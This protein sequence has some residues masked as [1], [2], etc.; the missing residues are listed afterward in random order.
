MDYLHIFDSIEKYNE[1]IG[2]GYGQMPAVGICDKNFDEV[3][4]RPTYVKPPVCELT[5]KG[6]TSNLF[7]NDYNIKSVSIDGEYVYNNTNE[8]TWKEFTVTPDDV[9][10]NNG[11][12]DSSLPNSKMIFIKSVP[13]IEITIE[14]G[15]L[16][17]DE[18]GVIFPYDNQQEI[19]VG[20]FNPDNTVLKDGVLTMD[21]T[22]FTSSFDNVDKVSFIIYRSDSGFLTT[23]IRCFSVDET[24]EEIIIENKNII[25]GDTPL[26]VPD[27]LKLFPTSSLYVD[28]ILIEK[29]DGPLNL[30]EDFIVTYY[31]GS[32]A[33]G[34]SLRIYVD[35]GFFLINDE[36]TLLMPLE[37]NMR[38]TL[39]G[40][41][42]IFGNCETD[43]GGSI[44]SITNFFDTKC[45]VVGKESVKSIEITDDKKTITFESFNR[46]APILL[47]GT[48]ILTY[49]SRAFMHNTSNELLPTQFSSSPYLESITLPK[50]IK[51]FDLTAINGCNNLKTIIC[52]TR[53]APDIPLSYSCNDIPNVI[54]QIPKG[55]DYS[56]WE[57]HPYFIKNNWKIEYV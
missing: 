27:N 1:S 51:N 31:A 55:G 8:R 32:F 6:P 9:S 44:V 14:G 40:T 45:T 25:P 21:F 5:Y 41:A 4:N 23:N 30:D 20:Q 28:Y 10:H 54:V 57:A 29:I 33:G 2:W 46:F 12:L 39:T 36:K 42:M 26:D 13:T 56:E 37:G 35:Y 18:C 19:L 47:Q 38:D 24:T 16:P 50:S 22:S 15:V 43:E 34:G 11:T 17:T 52:Q 7:Y 3:E 49:H 48:N 53:K